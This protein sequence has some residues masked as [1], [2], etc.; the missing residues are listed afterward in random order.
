MSN[1]PMT[2]AWNGGSPAF[3]PPPGVT[4]LRAG[5]TVTLQLTGVP[6]NGGSIDAVTIYT[7][8]VVDGQDSKGR[9]L[10]GWTRGGEDDCSVYDIAASSATRVKITDVEHPTADDKYWFSAAGTGNG[11]PWEVDPE[12]INKSGGGG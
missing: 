4:D 2:I 1:T 12:L 9:A 8:Q 6:G 5:D 10:C 7:N 3:N 11:I